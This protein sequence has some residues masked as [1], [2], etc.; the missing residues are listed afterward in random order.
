MC[1]QPGHNTRPHTPLPPSLFP[2]H[3]CTDDLTNGR[4]FDSQASRDTDVLGLFFDLLP[5]GLCTTRHWQS[6][7]RLVQELNI[8]TVDV[9]ICNV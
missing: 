5:M 1:G 6:S 3:G 8:C 4:S 2:G 7:G 9:K